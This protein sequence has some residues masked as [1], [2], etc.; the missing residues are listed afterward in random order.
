MGSLP[1]G[2]LIGSSAGHLGAGSR[3][4]CSPSSLSSLSMPRGGLAGGCCWR[5][6]GGRGRSGKWNSSSK[7]GSSTA[8]MSSHSSPAASSSTSPP[9]ASAAAEASS[10]PPPSSVLATVMYALAE[11]PPPLPPPPPR[12]VRCRMARRAAHAQRMTRASTADAR[13]GGKARGPPTSPPLSPPEACWP[14][15]VSS[16]GAYP[17]SVL[18]YNA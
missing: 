16:G 9:S 17:R 12:R 11:R 14:G 13:A 8:P 7:L 15:R 4:A 18:L 5:L 2:L 1:T 6:R 3:A 10:P